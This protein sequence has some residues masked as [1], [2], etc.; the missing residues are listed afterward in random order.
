MMEKSEKERIYQDL[1]D[2]KMKPTEFY[3]R[4]RK[5]VQKGSGSTPQQRHE[6]PRRR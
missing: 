5:L 6:E 1:K 4:W 3:P 2:G